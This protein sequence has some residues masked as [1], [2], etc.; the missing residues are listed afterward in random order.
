MKK[1]FVIGVIVLYSTSCVN[2]N[3]PSYKIP[4]DAKPIT[5]T[6]NQE[7]RISQDNEFAFDLLRK[8]MDDSKETNVFISPLS[9]SIALG[10]AW[11]GA[12]GQTKTEMET[13]LKTAGFASWEIKRGAGNDSNVMLIARVD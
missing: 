9:V 13:A 8:T 4:T 2:Q 6:A 10:M 3:D 11:N 5:L 1:L 7:K 12:N